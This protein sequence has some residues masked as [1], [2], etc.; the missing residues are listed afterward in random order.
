MAH[1]NQYQTAKHY[2]QAFLDEK[3]RS[4]PSFSLRAFAKKCGVPPSSLSAYLNDKS[5]LSGDSGVKIACQMNLQGSDFE[6]FLKLIVSE[7]DEKVRQKL[8][9]TKSALEELKNSSHSERV[10]KAFSNLILDE[11]LKY[12][13]P[14][15]YSFRILQF[16]KDKTT[17]Q[18]A[19]HFIDRFF[20]LERQVSFSGYHVQ[21]PSGTLSCYLQKGSGQ[22]AFERI[23]LG[24]NNE[25]KVRFDENGL[26]RILNAKIKIVGTNNWVVGDLIYELEKA[27]IDGYIFDENKP[28]LKSKFNVH[29]T[30]VK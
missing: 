7:S 24:E 2:L 14:G 27:Q 4:N 28:A 11:E 23:E 8:Q 18:R 3:Q 15:Q 6:Y 17:H 25:L 5:K 16:Y 30:R 9:A 19:K 20:S 22:S 10:K 29:Y 1:I 26:P 12:Q 13:V 21:N